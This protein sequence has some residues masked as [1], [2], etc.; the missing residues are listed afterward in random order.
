VQL[1]N[2]RIC[3]A[4]IVGVVLA[5]ALAGC[6]SSVAAGLSN[7]QAVAIGQEALG[8]TSSDSSPSGTSDDSGIATSCPDS[9]KAGLLAG[10]PSTAALAIL[11]PS[12]TAGVGADP[13]LTQGYT[14]SCA[15]GIAE[16]GKKTVDELYFIGISDADEKVITSRVVNDGFVGGTEAT[17]T[18]GTQQIF[19]KGS[20]GVAIDK[21]TLAGEPVLL[22]AG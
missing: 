10:L 7:S 18:S 14:A 4:V 22:I 2:R 20:A 8:F 3:G 21:L 6:S 5:N 16:S 15:F 17:I 1:G 13:E 9:L 12:V 19:T 11:N